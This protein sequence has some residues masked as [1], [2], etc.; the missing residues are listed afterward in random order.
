MLRKLIKYEFKATGR[1]FFP[2]YLALIIIAFIQRLFF[3]F[4]IE[5]M[6][7]IVINILSLIVPSLFGAIVMAICVVTFIMTIQRFYKNS[8]FRNVPFHH[9]VCSACSDSTGGSLAGT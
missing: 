7:S 9:A 1:I 3:Q 2:L 8:S 4:N 6:G 5:N